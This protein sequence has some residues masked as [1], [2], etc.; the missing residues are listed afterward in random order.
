MKNSILILL[1][2]F[3]VMLVTGVAFISNH[4]LNDGTETLAY[5]GAFLI[6]SCIYG[7]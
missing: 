2:V 1:I 5:V 4:Y 7:F 3:I 6:G